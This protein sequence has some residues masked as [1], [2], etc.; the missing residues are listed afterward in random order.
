MG[1]GL[2]TWTVA[3]TVVVAALAVVVAEPQVPCYFIFGDS[4]VDNGNNNNIQS[5][6]R[7]NYLPYGIDF[8]DGPTGRFSNGKT[9]VDVIAELLGFDDYIPPYSSARGEQILRG[10]NYASAAAGIRQE[11]GQQLGARIDFTGQVNN[12]KNTVSQV[13]QILGDEDTAADYL[14]KCIY[15]VGVGS[16]DYLNNYFMPQYYTTSRR[17]SPEEYADVLIQQYSEQIRALYN[18]GARKFALIGAGQIGCSPNA[19]AQNSPDGSTCVRRINSANQMFNNKLRALVD[20]FN[21]NSQDARFTYIDA[22]GIFQDLIDNP[23]AFGFRVTNAGCCGVGR[24]NGQITCLPFQTP[25]QNR[26]E[27][28]FWDAF[29][30]TEAANVIVGQRSYSAR[31]ASD[32]YPFDIRRLAQL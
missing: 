20:E 12:Y 3:L 19:L 24:N 32:A 13:V 31:K 26:D 27:Y 30:P 21:G 28:L 4:L 7:A 29:H 9:T 25:C 18:Y 2:K 6:A 1:S 8:P 23:S 22:Y 5:L 17:Y 15:S 14:S 10:V 11:T 16:N